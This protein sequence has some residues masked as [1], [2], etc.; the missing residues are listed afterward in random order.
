MLT[1]RSASPVANGDNTLPPKLHQD[2]QQHNGRLQALHS[3]AA[4]DAS[5]NTRIAELHN[6]AHIALQMHKHIQLQTKKNIPSISPN[7]KHSNRAITCHM[8]CRITAAAVHKAAAENVK[9]ADTN[10]SSPAAVTQV[11][12]YPCFAAAQQAAAAAARLSA[13]LPAQQPATGSSTHY[14]F[15]AAGT[16]PSVRS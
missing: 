7:D 4:A 10:P 14:A 16:K 9:H 12:S 2:A 8:A 11:A 5:V 1:C 3:T 15:A 13:V 6:N